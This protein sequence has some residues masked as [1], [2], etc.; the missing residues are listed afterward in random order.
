MHYKTGIHGTIEKEFLA[1]E[2]V[3][4]FTG[5]VLPDGVEAD[6]H[7]RKIV[8]KGSLV[9]ASGKV[10]TVAAGGTFSE[11]PA[12]ILM[13]ALDVTYGPQ[14]GALAVEAYVIGARLNLGVDYTAEIG[15]AIH[16][17]LPEIKFRNDESES[18]G[19]E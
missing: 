4:A 2:K 5:T 16:E 6:E 17:A 8:H 14:P 15:K 12:G 9:A 10:V 1:S 18:E 13:D 19:T 7:G 3:V 11:P